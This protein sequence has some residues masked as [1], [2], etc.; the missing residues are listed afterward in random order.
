MEGFH[1]R[2]LK[3]QRLSAHIVRTDRNPISHSLPLSSPKEVS[4]LTRADDDGGV[5][6]FALLVDMTVLTRSIRPR[7][8]PLGGRR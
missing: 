6:I 8:Q 2:L 7:L 3:L 1:P 4:H 5:S